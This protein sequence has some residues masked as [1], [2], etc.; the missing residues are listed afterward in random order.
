VVDFTA[1]YPA[2]IE[3]LKLLL[4][5][6]W[7]G[8]IFIVGAWLNAWYERRLLKDHL[9]VFDAQLANVIKIGELAEQNDEKIKQL[10]VNINDIDVKL[11]SYAQKA[12][13]DKLRA[14]T[15]KQVKGIRMPSLEGL[16]TRQELLQ[17]CDKLDQAVDHVGQGLV[18]MDAR[19]R[20][21][22]GKRKKAS[23]VGKE[24]LE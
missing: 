7:A 13:F 15:D 12:D 11:N 19:L 10:G 6:G 14:D 9:K 21:L 23:D 20:E 5:I 16:A 1:Y 4:S 22:E 3:Q 18:V 2:W 17:R 24:T 8:I